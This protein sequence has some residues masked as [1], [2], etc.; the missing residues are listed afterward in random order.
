M[1]FTAQVVEGLLTV[2]NKRPDAVEK[3]PEVYAYLK[4]WVLDGSNEIA[5]VLIRASLFV[6][7]IDTERLIVFMSD[8][9]PLGWCLGKDA[10]R[11]EWEKQFPG[12]KEKVWVIPPGSNVL[13]PV[14][15]L[16]GILDYMRVYLKAHPHVPRVLPPVPDP[17]AESQPVITSSVE[18]PLVLSGGDGPTVVIPKISKETEKDL[19]AKAAEELRAKETGAKPEKKQHVKLYNVKKKDAVKKVKK[20]KQPKV[21]PDRSLRTVFKG[22]LATI[23]IEGLKKP[24]MATKDIRIIDTPEALQAWVDNVLADESRWRLDVLGNL[25]PVV[26]VD[27]ET[28]GLDNRVLTDMLDDGSLVYEIKAEIAGLCLASHPNEGIYVPIHHERGRC[29]R[30]EDVARILQPLFDRA[31]L[32]F[33]NAKFDREILRLCL[34]MKMR[35]FP[36][37][38]DVQVLQYDNDP[39]ADLDDQKKKTFL[40]DAGGLKALSEHLLGWEQIKLEQ[41]IKVKATMKDSVT[42]VCKHPRSRHDSK[43]LESGCVCEAFAPKE[44]IRVQYAPF[45]WLPTDIALWYAAADATCTWGL[46]EKV[47]QPARTRRVI[48]KIDHKLVDTITW[49]E[50]QRFLIDTE[51]HAQTVKWH[52]G[53]LRL[54]EKR[55]QDIAV[56]DGWPVKKDDEGRVLEQSILN[57]NSNP[58]IGQLLFEIRKMPVV[59]KTEGDNA[60]VDADALK[61]LLKHYPNDPFLTEYMNYKEYVALHP[62]NLRYD[63]KD[64]TARVY[65]RQ[66][67]V[68]GGRLAA[69]GGEFDVDGGFELN[70]QGIKKPDDNWSVYGHLLVPDFVPPEQVE[71]HEESELHKSCFRG[72][73]KAKGIINNHIGNYLGYSICLVPTCT[74]CAQKFGILVENAHLDSNEVLNLRCLFI[75][76][77]GWTLF[78]VDYS[79]IEMR[80][81]ANCSLEKEFIKEFLEGEGDFHALTASKVFDEFN[82]PNTSKERRKYLRGLA[83]IMNFALLYG[84]TEYTICENLKKALPDI[85]LD[86]CREYY[87]KYWD[88]VPIF[89]QFCEDKKREAR[90]GPIPTNEPRWNPEVV[91][92]HGDVVQFDPS[93]RYDTDPATRFKEYAVYT[94][95]CKDRDGVKGGGEPQNGNPNWIKFMRCVT[96]IG[97]VV[98]FVSAMEAQGIHFPSPQENANYAQYRRYID[99]SE[100]AKAE[101]DKK[102]MKEWKDLAQALWMND[103]TGVKNVI[104]WKRFSGKIQRVSVNTPLQGLAGDFMRMSL[105]KIFQFATVHEPFVQTIFRLHATVHDE[106][107][108]IVKNEYVPYVLPR[109]T[110]LMKLRGLHKNVGWPVPIECDIEYGRSWD[111]QYHVTGDKDHA[112]VAWTKIKGLERYIPETF[113]PSMKPLLASLDSGDAHRIAK[114]KTW[115]ETNIDSHAHN[116]IKGVLAATDHNARIDALAV[117]FQ[118]HEYWITDAIPDENESELESFLVWEQRMGLGL[119]DRDPKSPPFGYI[120]T[121]PLDTNVI[122]PTLVPLDPDESSGGVPEAYAEVTVVL[123][124][125]EA[126]QTLFKS[127]VPP[128]E[129]PCPPVAVLKPLS[130]EDVT[131]LY[132]ALGKGKGSLEV[133]AVY[134]INGE[135]KAGTIKNCLVSTIPEEFLDKVTCQT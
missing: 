88:G 89:H 78:S 105:N 65:F 102:A 109:I 9:G 70:P 126:Q 122:R 72:G 26:A 115:L 63:P 76:P 8:T 99:N 125:P 79:N 83:K 98:S 2:F 69:Q 93:G 90:E 67:V 81:A 13:H 112:P 95:I 58:Q 128:V 47:L 114:V 111:V 49:I 108:F 130:S 129:A 1:S 85:T 132:N 56:A 35:P 34:G 43:C 75:A 30:R 121:I 134:V 113:M 14:T 53:K 71:P 92:H 37:F 110:R 4:D 68:A 77:E 64:H 17:V 62:E 101:G 123:E 23:N 60:S 12:A 80:A 120:G 46:W 133:P 127:D 82:D 10:K 16:K 20:P 124:P 5:G 45:N 3:Y 28:I 106:I 97:R 7:K 52:Q 96:A 38:E 87:K 61:D 39:K 100:F 50:R 116:A 131:R 33:Y 104:D 94:C 40:S 135:R 27:A 74:T 119:S 66:N 118:L 19:I 29:M 86:K 21:K 11:E 24:W 51:R 36:Y 107:D 15:E 31:H 25:V 44:S 6:E 42:C 73:K 41:L 54:I 117:I 84:G 59:K 48:H 57:V 91:Y 103:D 22:H 55:L 32:I 18:E